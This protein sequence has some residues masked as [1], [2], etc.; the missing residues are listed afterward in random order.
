MKRIAELR[1]NL[2]PT[3]D[4]LVAAA[5]AAESVPETEAACTAAGLPLRA[6]EGAWAYLFPLPS[7]LTVE[8]RAVAEIVALAMLPFYAIAMPTDS[9]ANLRWLGQLPPG[10]MET[11]VEFDKRR[12]PLWRALQE[13]A[14]SAKSQEQWW[15][16]LFDQLPG[17]TRLAA[18][19]FVNAPNNQYCLSPRENAWLV[20]N[21]WL[22]DGLGVG[23]AR[24]VL[25][26]DS[27]PDSN[28][29]DAFEKQ[30][31]FFTMV[32]ARVK[33]EAT[34]DQ[35]LPIS[36]T[37]PP[38]IAVECVAALP[39]L[40]REEAI[41]AG[42]QRTHA[43]SA[44]QLALAL[45]EKF[46]FA[47]LARF[48]MEK[49]ER[50]TPTSR[51]LERATLQ[52]IAKRQPNIAKALG[53]IS[54]KA[55]VPK[56]P[57]AISGSGFRL[58]NYRKPFQGTL[59]TTPPA[60]RK[61][62]T[63]IL[64]RDLDSQNYKLAA[65]FDDS[66]SEENVSIKALEAIDVIDGDT[67]KV[68]ANLFLYPFGDGAVVKPGSL[69]MLANIVQHEITP[70]ASTSAQWM[71]NFAHAWRTDAA[72]I[73]VADPGHFDIDEPTTKVK[74][75]SKAAKPKNKPTPSKKNAPRVQSKNKPKK[76]A[77]VAAKTKASPVK[78]KKRASKLAPAAKGKQQRRAKR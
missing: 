7:D 39:E 69:T 1:K 19:V 43:H 50:S 14:Q 13:A 4:A 16:L 60:L 44:I 23:W 76:K 62:L 78:K 22:R 34:W 71:A 67:G 24:K 68:V 36:E 12:L 32:R 58:A 6:R 27:G 45:A 18:L 56:P 74:A 33:L 54:K 3:L 9:Q 40:R 70:H 61:Q 26:T 10:T 8:Q 17:D 47:S 38:D 37:V 20:A 28:E 21:G 51:K 42:L 5:L 57:P 15:P 75:K 29:D 35:F 52:Q 41:L 2:N 73:G 77:T 30:L 31:A 11:L 49:S 64:A 25:E 48:V 59:K 53:E 63:A 66:L 72:K 55:P 65:L 46:D